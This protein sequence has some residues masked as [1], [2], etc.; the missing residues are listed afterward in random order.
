[1]S[2]GLE[3]KVAAIVALACG[4]TG[5]CG[6]PHTKGGKKTG[7]PC[8]HLPSFHT[9]HVAAPADPSAPVVTGAVLLPWCPTCYTPALRLGR[10]ARDQAREAAA[11][12]QF[13]QAHLF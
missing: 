1:M 6:T 10:A 7:S 11:A 4:C 13:P 2:D 5:Q 8:G 9:R 12:D 3:K